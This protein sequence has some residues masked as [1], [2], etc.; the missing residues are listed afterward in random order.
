MK[1][2]NKF[3]FLLYTYL[4]SEM[5]APF[6][7][8]FII[9]NCVF[10]LVKLIPFL[11]FVL[12]L[13]I[14]FV[15]FIKIFSY[16]FPNMF[17][18]SIPMSAMI[19]VTIAFSRLS[20]DTE[21]LA[22][23]A[24][25][26]SMYQMLPPVILVTVSLGLLTSYFSIKLIPVSDRNI[27][28]FTYQLLKEKIDK[29]IKERQF[30]EA[31]GDIVVYVGN[32]DKETNN[33]SDVWVS[34]MRGQ[35]TP[36][37]TMAEKGE[38][39]TELDTFVVTINLENGSLHRPDNQDSQIILFDNYEI[40]I[41]LQTP[42]S[43]NRKFNRGTL[44]MLQLQQM[45]TGLGRDSRQ[46]RKLI[47]E[48]HKRL[49][50]PVGCMILALIG[51]PLGLQAGPGKRG[52]GIPL[53]LIVFISYYVL[54]T[55][56]KMLSTD[57]QIP[58]VIAMWAPN[59]FYFFLTGLMIWRTAN[60]LPLMPEPVTNLFFMIKNNIVSRFSSPSKELDIKSGRKKK[61]STAHLNKIADRLFKKKLTIK[62]NAKSRVFHL[63]ECEF[64]ECKNCSIEFKNVEIALE[65]NFTPCKFCKALIQNDSYN[66]DNFA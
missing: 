28:Q 41:P 17:L 11:N 26:I 63:P 7:A 38:M 49:V 48:Y 19:G 36:T 29:G 62:A 1:I 31:L 27:E 5:L 4:A 10:F 20:N 44:D 54:F 9:M 13:D 50:L 51:L 32:V 39:H 18:Y 53:G 21:I 43:T 66:K 12:E 59:T 22:F 35:D 3:P 34:D 6:F 60:E 58:I 42:G 24:T 45:A 57:T 47:T 55:F 25:G 61:E 8:S 64:Y 2:S 65:A 46:G 52:I 23:K 40:N 30:T 14:S 33:W 16:L 37:I 56:A 15:D